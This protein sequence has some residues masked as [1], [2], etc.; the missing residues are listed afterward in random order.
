MAVEAAGVRRGEKTR[1]TSWFAEDAAPAEAAKTDDDGIAAFVME[2]IGVR[3]QT[4]RG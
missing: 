1:G 2:G 3:E 4:A